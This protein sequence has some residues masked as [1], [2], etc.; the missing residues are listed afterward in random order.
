MVE[1]NER[2]PRLNYLWVGPPR[3]DAS[4]KGV[5]GSDVADV[6]DRC[7]IRLVKI[8]SDYQSRSDDKTKK[9]LAKNITQH[10]DSAY[11]ALNARLKNREESSPNDIIESFK[12]NIA[13][14][15]QQARLYHKYKHPLTSSMGKKVVSSMHY[16]K[17]IRKIL[18]IQQLL[19]RKN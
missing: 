11:Q 4:G 16:K 5:L 15:E 2:L 7:T 14:V 8:T 3:V 13:A 17:I 1:K 12:K 18:L 10:I 6:I 19:I 9:Q